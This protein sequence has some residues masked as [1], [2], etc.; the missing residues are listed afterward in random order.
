MAKHVINVS[1]SEQ[2]IQQAIKEL[3]K[4]KRDFDK[5]LETLAMRLAREGMYLAKSYLRQYKDKEYI[6]GEGDQGVSS[7]GASMQDIL[8]SIEYKPGEVITDGYT[9]YIMTGNEFAP[10]VEF[11]TGIIGQR[12]PHEEPTWTY[13]VNKHGESGWFYFDEQGKAHWTK[14][15]PAR[16]FM[17]NTVVELA[18]K[19]SQ[20]ARE[21]FG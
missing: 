19:A 3:E 8:D 1:L 7:V 9:Y 5:K 11:G 18:L 16:P 10:Y 2:S 13:D 14:G 21:V 4:Y 17:Y 20:I 12:N 6:F 15:V